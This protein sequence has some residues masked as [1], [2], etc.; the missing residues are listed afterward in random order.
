MSDETKKRDAQDAYELGPVENVND[1]QPDSSA[2]PSRK[3]KQQ[4]RIVQPDSSG[5]FELEGGAKEG[6]GAPIHLGPELKKDG[7]PVIGEYEAAYNTYAV[8]LRSTLRAMG[9]VKDVSLT[10]APLTPAELMKRP[11]L[12]A[13]FR[14][15]NPTSGDVQ[16]DQA[17]ND[18]SNNQKKMTGDIQ[19]F[20]GGQHQMAAVLAN[21]RSVQKKL[22][23][24]RVEAERSA[25]Q[26]EIREIEE[27][28][29]TLSRIVEFT[30]EALAASGEIEEMLDRKVA[31]DE[32]AEGMEEGAGEVSGEGTKTKKQRAAGAVQDAASAGVIGK[33]V[34]SNARDQLAKT[35]K[36]EMN[37]Q[38]IF[39][40]V[41]GGEKYAQLQRD[42]VVLNA[43][44]A[45]LKLDAE[46]EEV[47][48]ANEQLMGFKMEFISTQ[49][50]VRTDRV[51]SRRGA[52]TFAKSM[53]AGADGIDAMYAAEAYQELANFGALAAQQRRDFV[54]PVWGRAHGY[55]YGYDAHRFE[56]IGAMEDARQLATNLQAVQEQRGYLGK[57][58]PEWQT[59]AKQWDAFLKERT[60]NALDGGATEADRKSEAP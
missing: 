17:F 45:S 4:Q 30:S 34:L 12:A 47:K 8:P 33:S 15:L 21:Y 38:G 46:A 51:A 31:L 6:L 40:A 49:Q 53:N 24:R 18:W 37:L 43:K 55:V 57:H 9:R 16:Q 19:R 1:L 7:G 50:N 32:N 52:K 60:G 42:T 29:E 26:A 28:A 44:I 20:G 36:F 3:D 48:S 41:V 39:L 35:G 27:T 22:A 58:V 10:G 54:D 13:R 5:Y 25:K 56:A 11:D 59:V 23:Q 2:G 14:K